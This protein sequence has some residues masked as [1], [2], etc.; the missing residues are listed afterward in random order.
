MAEVALAQV[1]LVGAGLLIV[2]YLRLSQI[3]PGFNADKVLTAKIAPS[4]KKYP[5]ARSRAILYSAVLDHLKNLPG[6]KSAGMVMNL[7][8]S[9]AS[10]NRGFQVEGRPEPKADENVAMDYQVI[11]P[12]YFATLDVPII[13]GRGL[14]DGDSETSEQVIVIN[15]AMAQ[16]FWP[17]EDPLGK[18]MAIGES[19]KILRGAIIG[20]SGDMRHASLSD[21]AVPTAFISYRQDLES[22]P[23]MAFVIKSESEATNLTSAVRKE[24]ISIDPAQPVYGV[25]PLA[26]LLS[27]SVAQ[28]RFV[29]LLVGSLS[30]VA[31]VLAMIGV[32][33]V[34]SFSVSERTHEIGIRMALGAR[35]KDVLAMI[36]SQGMRLAL[37][38]MAIGI[39]GA[40]ALTRLLA[41]LLFEVSATDPQTFTIV[42]VLVGLLRCWPVTCRRARNE[43]RSCGA[44]LRVMSESDE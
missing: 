8:L 15:Q 23:R 32:Y 30:L 17:G 18:R 35:G 26:K 11:S 31:L 6:V 2:S 42:A 39:T 40:V 19:S 13:R 44:A 9:G 38:G 12:D 7:P 43:S 10:M 1:L 22:W 14:T 21:A 16:R 28:R 5:D 20:I 27:T 41:G 24:L 25:E 36:L 37:V 3:N 4:S 33:G 29:M 34:I